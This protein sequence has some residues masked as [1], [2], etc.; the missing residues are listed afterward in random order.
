MRHNHARVIRKTAT[1]RTCHSARAAKPEST[2]C[3]TLERH[4]STGA[5]GPKKKFSAGMKTCKRTQRLRKT[6]QLFR[7]RKRIARIGRGCARGKFRKIFCATHG[8]ARRRSRQCSSFSISS[9]YA[10]GSRRSSDSSARLL[11]FTTKIQPS[12]NA[13]SLIVSGLSASAL[14]TEITSPETGA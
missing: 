9:A 1:A 5:G 4:R 10:S 6:A 12:P 8:E 14:L 3:A 11:G 2:A 7:I 13:S